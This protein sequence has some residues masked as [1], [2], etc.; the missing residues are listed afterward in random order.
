MR[1]R[2]N[3]GESLFPSG[4]ESSEVNKKQFTKIS[5]RK[6]LKQEF[7]DNIPKK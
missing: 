5:F 2:I 1:K 4:F 6:F 3:E 7:T